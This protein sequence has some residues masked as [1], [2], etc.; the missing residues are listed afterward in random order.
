MGTCPDIAPVAFR[1][2]FRIYLSSRYFFGITETTTTIPITPAMKDF[3]YPP[4]AKLYSHT[5]IGFYFH[6]DTSF[7][8]IP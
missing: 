8:I 3:I 7:G 6:S 1:R 2:D 4:Y 5:A